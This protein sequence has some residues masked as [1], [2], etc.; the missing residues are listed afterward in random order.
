MMKSRK[1]SLTKNH[2]I[3]KKENS[4]NGNNSNM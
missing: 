2:D 3:T 1:D 4:Q